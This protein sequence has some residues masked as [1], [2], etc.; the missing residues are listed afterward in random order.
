[1]TPTESTGA[2]EPLVKMFKQI[3][4]L[5]HLAWTDTK[6][7]RWLF[8]QIEVKAIAGQAHVAALKPSEGQRQPFFPHTRG[9]HAD[10][11]QDTEPCYCDQ[12]QAAVPSEGGTEPPVSLTVTN[13]APANASPP[14]W[15]HSSFV[16]NQSYPAAPEGL[17]QQPEVVPD[18]LDKCLDLLLSTENFDNAAGYRRARN[19]LAQFI[20]SRER[21]ALAQS[22]GR[23][24]ATLKTL[25]EIKFE[26]RT[27]G[28]DDI[29]LGMIEPLER[30]LRGDK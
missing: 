25:G 4:N 10:D 17:E 7:I 21:A 26:L 8:E 15:A 2:H 14:S 13:G 6:N 23:V 24:A 27:R 11:P 30:R 3:E 18:D 22:E 1:M 28:V 16:A 9:S 29:A 19:D 5:A 12:E 20:H